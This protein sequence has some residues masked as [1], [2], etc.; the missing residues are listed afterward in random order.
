[1]NQLTWCEVTRTD[2]RKMD[3]NEIRT[4]YNDM[5]QDLS[6]EYTIDFSGNMVIP[7]NK[8]RNLIGNYYRGCGLKNEH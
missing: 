5:C 1:M 7:T 3:D 8:Q 6:C 2:L 4:M